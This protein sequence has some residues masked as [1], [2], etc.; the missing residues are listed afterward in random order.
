MDGPPGLWPGCRVFD[1]AAGTQGSMFSHAG[2]VA[3]IT[4]FTSHAYPCFWVPAD[5][6]GG[7][8]EAIPGEHMQSERGRDTGKQRGKSRSREA[9]AK[10]A[11]RST[12]GEKHREAQ[13]SRAACRERTRQRSTYKHRQEP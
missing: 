6:T 4:H 9:H 5:S 11:K 3:T 10:K 7:E 2:R 1:G 12:G 8:T 13:T